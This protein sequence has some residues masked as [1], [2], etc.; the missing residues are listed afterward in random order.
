[1]TSRLRAEYSASERLPSISSSPRNASFRPRTRSLAVSLRCF[2]DGSGWGG[3]GWS[4]GLH[5]PCADEAGCN[6][7]GSS[8][9]QCL[10]HL[11]C[12]SGQIHFFSS[13][14]SPSQLLKPV[15]EAA[16]S[17]A[18]SMKTVSPASAFLARLAELSSALSALRPRRII[19][20]LSSTEKEAAVNPLLH[21]AH[22]PACSSSHISR[23]R[24][25][26]MKLLLKPRALRLI[27]GKTL[28]SIDGSAVHFFVTTNQ[29]FQR[30]QRRF[31]QDS[32]DSF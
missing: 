15:D 14:G 20:L 5:S 22:S 11:Q 26:E 17:S 21:W 1:M 13:S 23:S 16:A 9:G 25:P 2:S 24:T 6:R 18:S 10:P 3:G 31:L 32:A 27:L 29:L 4:G 12:L 8:N 19:I 30:S 7:L 28:T